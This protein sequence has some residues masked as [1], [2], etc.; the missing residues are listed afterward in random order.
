MK[1]KSPDGLVLAIRRRILKQSVKGE[2]PPRYYIKLSLER[3][4]P[5]RRALAEWGAVDAEKARMDE[6][7][8]TMPHEYDKPVRIFHCPVAIQQSRLAKRLR[9]Q[10]FKAMA[11]L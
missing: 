3:W 9:R 5:L 10:G 11:F 6:A 4:R 1:D 2:P 7:H 8:D